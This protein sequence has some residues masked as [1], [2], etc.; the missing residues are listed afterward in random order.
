MLRFKRIARTTDDRVVVTDD[1][2]MSISAIY[3]RSNTNS[4]AFLLI[5]GPDGADFTFDLDAFV[6]SNQIDDFAVGDLVEATL[7]PQELYTY[8]TDAFNFHKY[9]RH[10]PASNVPERLVAR[11]CKIPTQEESS[12]IDDPAF[13]D[14]VVRYATF[15][16]NLTLP[17]IDG[18]VYPAS[19][20][21]GSIYISNGRK[22][23]LNNPDFSFLSFAD[24]SSIQ[25]TSL[26]ELSRHDWVTPPGYRA[27]TIIGGHFMHGVPNI[28]QHRDFLIIS[29][30]IL[31]DYPGLDYQDMDELVDD[32]LSFV[33]FVQVTEIYSSRIPVIKLSPSIYQFCTPTRWARPI[34][35]ITLDSLSR[36]MIDATSIVDRYIDI[37][38]DSDPYLR[39]LYC[40]QPCH[41]EISQLTLV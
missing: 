16:L 13:K 12:L 24:A 29:P 40:K 38:R 18:V 36:T 21:D 28:R 11:S 14:M 33:V 8:Q 2:A 27:V 23:L 22:L 26:A 25:I 37:N 1:G 10:F 4:K 5:E 35:F 39:H 15:N 34:D 30:T 31:S 19:W 17:V 6:T 20:I 9:I 7:T 3:T 32:P 41:A